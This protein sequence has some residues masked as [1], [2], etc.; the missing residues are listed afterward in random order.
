PE[1][2]QAISTFS[3]SDLRFQKGQKSNNPMT[4]YSS[5]S[6]CSSFSSGST[7]SD[8]SSI[9]LSALDILRTG[10]GMGLKKH[11]MPSSSYCLARPLSSREHMTP[12]RPMHATSHTDADQM[13]I[14]SPSSQPERCS[15]LDSSRIKGSWNGVPVKAPPADAQYI[16]IS[17][18]DLHIHPGQN[19]VV[20]E[21]HE[22][23]SQGV[24]YNPQEDLI[25]NLERIRHQKKEERRDRVMS[26][27][28]T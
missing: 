20:N 17:P 15:S 1:Y 19:R 5:G 12:R 13:T 4:R 26:W 8:N 10:L 11:N 9:S 25:E 7:S 21:P 27:F 2:L 6:A 14:Q 18:E 22:P 24:I 23:A 16:K 28:L 3:P